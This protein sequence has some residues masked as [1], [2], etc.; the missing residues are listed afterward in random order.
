MEN[1]GTREEQF[2]K[3]RGRRGKMRG[4]VLFL[5]DKVVVQPDVSVAIPLQP[6]LALAVTGGNGAGLDAAEV[7]GDAGPEVVDVVVLHRHHPV[8][9]A[10][11]RAKYSR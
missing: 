11:L 9:V 7:V 5:P 10:L 1:L 4:V 2:V 8:S 6:R 3:L